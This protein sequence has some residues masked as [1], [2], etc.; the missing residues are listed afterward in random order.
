M[1][2]SV[3][4]LT[5]ARQTLAPVEDCL[6]Q[7]TAVCGEC[8]ILPQFPVNKNDLGRW[9]T[10]IPKPASGFQRRKRL[11]L[12]GVSGPPN[13]SMIQCIALLSFATFS[14]EEEIFMIHQTLEK[15]SNNIFRSNYGIT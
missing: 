5:K 3:S 14:R 1:L 11:I 7:M 9:S 2:F 15:T 6:Q 4:P 8:E 12:N 10:T 13:S